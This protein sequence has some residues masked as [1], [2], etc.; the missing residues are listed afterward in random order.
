MQTD[1]L[2][3]KND[4]LFLKKKNIFILLS[5]FVCHKF[6]LLCLTFFKLPWRIQANILLISLSFGSLRPLLRFHTTLY[7]FSTTL[8]I[9]NIHYH[10]E[11]LNNIGLLLSRADCIFVGRYE[12]V[13]DTLI[14][15]LLS[16]DD[17]KIHFARLSWRVFSF[18]Q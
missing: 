5:R 14:Y 17:I 3:M 2:K 1:N 11:P 12:N 7:F 13:S 9:F 18:F 6:L 4:C 10:H 8:I 15:F 16:F